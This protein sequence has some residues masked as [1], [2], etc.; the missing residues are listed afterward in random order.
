VPRRIIRDGLALSAIAALLALSDA[1]TPRAD[2]PPAAA[3]GRLDAN[4]NANPPVP[5]LAPTI[6]PPV[7]RDLAALWMVPADRERSAAMSNPA[8]GHLQSALKLYAQDKYDQALAGFV[9]AAAAGSPLRDYATYY[10]GVSELRLKR[11]DAAKRR[12]A[13]LKDITGFLSEA[14]ALGQ[15]EAAQGLGDY[16]SATHLYDRLLRAKPIDEPAILLSLATAATASND[17]KRAAEAYLR[18]YYEYPLS[19]FASQAEGPLQTL[20]S[21]GDVQPIEHGNTHYKLELGRAER[22]F[23]SRRHADARVSF[24]RL[25]PYATGDDAELVGL[26][27]AEIDYFS[28]RYGG[29]RQALEPYLD[30]AARRAEARFFNLMAQ[31]GLKNTD[32][33]V[34]LARALANDFPDSSWAEEAL[35]TLATYYIQQNDDDA[36]DVVLREMYARFPRGRYA[37]RAAWKVGWRAY[38]VGNMG[39][40]AQYFESGAGNFVRSDYRPAWLYWS[41]RARQRMGDAATAAARYQLTVTD[42]QNTYYGRLAT[43]QLPGGT[44]PTTLVFVTNVTELGGEADQFPPN[45]AAIRALLSLSMYEPAL[46]E[47]EFAQK[48][49]GGSPAIDATTAWLNWRRSFGAESGMAQLLLARSAMNQ[50]KR[51]YPQYM[52]AGGEQLPREILTTIFPLTFWDLITKYSAERELDPYLVAALVAQESTFVPTVRSHANAYGLM[53]LLPSTGRTYARKLKLRYSPGLLTSAEPNIRM[54]VAYFADKVREFGS[55]PLALASYNAGESPVRRWLAE[56]DADMPQEEF[57]DDIPY[58][59]TQNYVKRILGTAEDY[60]RLYGSK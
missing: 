55:V 59:E 60:R 43:K 45:A 21:T 32:S 31:R 26:R 37:E 50:M 58:P 15:A 54:G 25:K 49:W 23:G 42:Y 48:K 38:R 29:A 36:A 57:I 6:H 33:F 34:V 5:P 28:D 17:R 18:L 24:L 41:A 44:A 53:Q 46:K 11:F 3:V 10:A 4:A 30:T 51:A 13:Q 52:A 40:A 56:R 2:S 16:E 1:A 7:A 8:L 27:L 19:E 22:L 20:T 9:L 14:T 35:N 39:D 12:F 47:L